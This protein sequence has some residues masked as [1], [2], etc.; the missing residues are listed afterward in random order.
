MSWVELRIELPRQD[1]ER[2]SAMLFALGASGTQED[3]LPGQA[4]ALRQ[5]WDTGPEPEPPPVVL[6]RAWFHGTDTA[7]MTRLLV[8]AGVEGSAI[9]WEPF[10]EVDWEARFRSGFAPLEISERLVVAPPWDAPPGSVIIEPGQGFGTGAHP[11]TRQALVALDALADRVASVLDVGCGSGILAL[12][13]AKLGKRAVGVDV[14]EAAIA[15]ARENARRN[16]LDVAFSTTPVAKLTEAWD[17]VLAN[18][19]AELLVEM[20][21]DLR[22]LTA[23]WLVLAGILPDRE[24]MVRQAFAGFALRDRS[25]DRD[26]VCLVLERL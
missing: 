7:A 16:A 22:R 25:V 3:H 21:A 4:P 20:S 10:E 9:A 26:W 17:L 6:L 14:D 8:A 23:H 2:V 11:T 5:P 24:A 13:A 18:L 15:D 19:Y 1:I 12:S